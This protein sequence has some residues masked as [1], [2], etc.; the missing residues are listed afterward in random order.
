MLDGICRFFTPEVPRLSNSDLEPVLSGI[1]VPA[2]YNTRKHGKEY[3]DSHTLI[4]MRVQ[5]IYFPMMAQDKL[6]I[7]RIME[8]KPSQD[9][10]VALSSCRRMI[11]IGS[12][13][14]IIQMGL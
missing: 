14:T 2:V 1:Q 8:G 11:R 6:H 13:F 3:I 12:T 4:A 5:Q 7:Y 10:P 9:D